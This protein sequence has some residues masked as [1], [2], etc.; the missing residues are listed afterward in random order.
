MR[1]PATPRRPSSTSSISPPTESY[2]L[3]YRGRHLGRPEPGRSATCSRAATRGQ[4]DSRQ[5]RRV[6]HRQRI[7]AG[8]GHPDRPGD[9]DRQPVDRR[10]SGDGHRDPHVQLHAGGPEQLREPVA[11][12]VVTDTIPDGIEFL[13]RD[14]RSGARPRLSPTRPRRRASREL[15]WTLGTMAPGAIVTIIYDDRHP[16]RLLRHRQRRHQPHHDDFSSTPATAAIIP[17]K[18]DFTNTAG[19]TSE[20]HGSLPATITPTDS[21]SASVTGAYVTIDKSRHAVDW[22]LR[23]RRG[24]HAHVRHLAVLRGRHARR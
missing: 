6:A 10:A 5:Q 17:H 11:I 14:E 18:T 23:H 12:V 1:R 20:Y 22:R 4:Q 8:G 2:T 3:T 13:G 21:D 7:G 15:K 24:L 9:E 16:I 19:L